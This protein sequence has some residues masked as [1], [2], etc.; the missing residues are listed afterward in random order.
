V[1]INGFRQEIVGVADVK[2]FGR[3]IGTR[4]LQVLSRPQ[5]SVAAWSPSDGALR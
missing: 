3:V 1:G 4:K 5:L 2:E